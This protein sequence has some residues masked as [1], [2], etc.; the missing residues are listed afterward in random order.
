MKNVYH[1][2]IYPVI[3]KED[4]D[5]ETDLTVLTLLFV[6]VNLKKGGSLWSSI[7]DDNK[8]LKTFKEALRSFKGK[9]HPNS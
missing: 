2:V 4:E 1:L 9:R 8:K 5:K 6:Y 7:S 3:P